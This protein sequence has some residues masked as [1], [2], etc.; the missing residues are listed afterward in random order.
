MQG[1]IGQGTR[2]MPG[3]DALNDERQMAGVHFPIR[4]AREAGSS[5]L[6][7]PHSRHRTAPL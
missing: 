6:S 2:R 4:Y 5:I 7:R 3:A 1:S